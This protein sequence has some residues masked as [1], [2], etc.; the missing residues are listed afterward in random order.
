MKVSYPLQFVCLYSVEM[1]AEE[2]DAYQYVRPATQ[3]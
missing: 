1:L 3:N 2:G